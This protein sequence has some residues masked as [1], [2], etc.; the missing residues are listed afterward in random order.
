VGVCGCEWVG[1]YLCVGGCVRAWVSRFVCVH[2]CVFVYV[3][4]HRGD[5]FPPC[6]QVQ[7]V[8]VCVCVW[9]GICVC[10]GG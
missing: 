10:E 6:A 1:G 4:L 8:Y 5:L 3:H 2:V 7:G 9:V